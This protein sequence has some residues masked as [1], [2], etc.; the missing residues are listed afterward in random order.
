MTATAR[1]LAL[2][3]LKL[4]AHEVVAAGLAHLHMH[5]VLH[6]DLNMAN[7]LLADELLETLRAVFAGQDLIA[8]GRGFYGWG[9]RG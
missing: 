2:R 5:S 6:R 4:P 8:H 1:G 9:H 3:P 7:V